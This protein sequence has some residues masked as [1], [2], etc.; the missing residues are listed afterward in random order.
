LA[1]PF[2]GAGLPYT[3][4]VTNPAYAEYHGFMNTSHSY[5][6][7]RTYARL[8]PATVVN[9]SHYPYDAY[10]APFESFAA[11]APAA[12]LA[13]PPMMAAASPFVDFQQ[14]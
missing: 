7:D 2:H 5:G 14:Y 4:A 1:T 12:P 10:S 8:S 3:G 11:Y 9:G 13:Y 6:L